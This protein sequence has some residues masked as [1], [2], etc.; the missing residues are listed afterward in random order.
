MNNYTVL[1]FKYFLNKDKS[2]FI[3]KI[4]K[5]KNEVLIIDFENK[6]LEIQTY[7]ELF[8]YLFLESKK[9][10]ICRNISDKSFELIRMWQTFCDI[11]KR[12]KNGK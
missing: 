7:S 9:R 11:E 10:I 1:K 3:E 6:E 12:N 8:D 2:F 5:D 4:E